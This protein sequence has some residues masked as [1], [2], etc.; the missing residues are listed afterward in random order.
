[1]Q[2][3]FEV[4]AATPKRL[5]AADDAPVAETMRGDRKITQ[6]P[7]TD[8]KKVRRQM[9]R[10]T[11]ALND[12]GDCRLCEGPLIPKSRD[13][14]TVKAEC[15]DCGTEHSLQSSTI[16]KAS[17]RIEMFSNLSDFER[18][19]LR[20][21]AWWRESVG[22]CPE[23]G[24]G[25]I[26]GEGWADGGPE[27]WRKSLRCEK[28]QHQYHVQDQHP[29]ESSEDFEDRKART[30]P[31]GTGRAAASDFTTLLSLVGST[32]EPRTDV[33]PYLGH[34]GMSAIARRAQSVL[35]TEEIQ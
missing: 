35:D 16:D 1:M 29:R 15:G 6:A 4:T 21:L 33:S 25:S 34:T 27:G 31:K 14:S 11:A 18:D 19:R 7:S 28:C 10:K 22:N 24:H 30:K 3:G 2:T 9:Q 8:Q 20:V 23:C 32:W 26:I 13:G 17:T 5:R 12:V